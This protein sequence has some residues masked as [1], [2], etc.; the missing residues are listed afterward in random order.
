MNGGSCRPAESLPV[1]PR[2][3]QASP[4]SFPQNLSFEL[5][6]NRQKAGHRST[7]GSGQIQRLGQRHE[8]YSEMF[9]LLKG[10]Q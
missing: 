8:T 2:M 7:G 1:L 10:C 4:S 3:R 6:E 9:Q 5:S